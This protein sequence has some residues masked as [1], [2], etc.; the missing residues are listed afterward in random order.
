[1]VKILEKEEFDDLKEA[2]FSHYASFFVCVFLVIVVSGGGS[3][4]SHI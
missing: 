2:V 4:V 3:G 1:M